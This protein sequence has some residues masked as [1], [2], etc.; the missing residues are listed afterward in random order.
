MYLRGKLMVRSILRGG[1]IELFQSTEVTKAVVCTIL[2]VGW[3][4]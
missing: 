3:C 2:S 1:P 4:I